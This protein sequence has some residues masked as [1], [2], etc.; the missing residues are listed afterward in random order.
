MLHRCKLLI[1]DIFLQRKEH[2]MFEFF[3]LFFRTYA[4]KVIMLHS[5]MSMLRI[6]LIS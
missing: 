5:N 4:M 1:T 6:N 3:P 2:E